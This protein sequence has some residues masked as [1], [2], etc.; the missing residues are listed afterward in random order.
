MSRRR[1]VGLAGGFGFLLAGV[2]AAASSQ[3]T[4]G[5]L[6]VWAT[7]AGT[8]AA[9]AAITGW[10]VSRTTPPEQSSGAGPVPPAK[11]EVEAAPRGRDSG[12]RAH[13]GD[14]YVGDVSANRGGQAIGVNYGTVSRSADR[15]RHP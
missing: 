11:P 3:L 15:G 12:G 9:G 13:L 1:P 2:S 10:L 6:W 4:S 7:F 14:V 8:L 5:A